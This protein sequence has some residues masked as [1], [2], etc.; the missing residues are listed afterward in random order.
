MERSCSEFTEAS[1]AKDLRKIKNH[2]VCT[3]INGVF[4]PLSECP[5][6]RGRFTHTG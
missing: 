2:T 6:F 1:G 3:C 4:T 5:P